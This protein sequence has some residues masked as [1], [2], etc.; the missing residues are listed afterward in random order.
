[1]K[2]PLEPLQALSYLKENKR[3]HWLEGDKSDECLDIIKTALKDYEALKE[4]RCVLFSGR[5]NGKTYDEVTRIRIINK[6]KVLEII[7][8][9]K[10]MNY[11]IKNKKCADMYHLN[12]E[13]IELLKEALL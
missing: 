5:M 11:V 7:K 8:E 13:E 9:H 3:K 6:L 12:N 1:M 4:S 2:P 10:L